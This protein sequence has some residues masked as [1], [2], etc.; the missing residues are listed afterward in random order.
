MFHEYST[1]GFGGFLKCEFFGIYGLGFPHWGIFR[2]FGKHI[3][4]ATNPNCYHVWK[5]RS[6]KHQRQKA[7]KKTLKIAIICSHRSMTKL[8]LA[9]ER[10][11]S[12]VASEPFV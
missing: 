1:R 10:F 7:S 8:G 4:V 3:L 9:N 5:P 11:S 12:L 6:A 2:Y